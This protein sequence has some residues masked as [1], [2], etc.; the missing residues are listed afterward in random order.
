M[1]RLLRLAVFT[2]LVT[3]APAAAQTPPPATPVVRTP[4][5][6]AL[7]DLSRA[8]WRWMADQHM[9]SLSALFHDEAVFVH[10]GGTMPR[11]TELEIIRS[12]GIRYTHAEVFEAS[13]RVLG[14][15]AIVL[16]RIRLDAIV[17]G[18]AVTNPFMVTEVYVRQGSGW[19]L[20]ALSFTRLLQ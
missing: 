3:A 17:G 5:E 10:M 15:T 4:T 2:A 18:N 19:Q 11:A 7:L 13:V 12:G 8:K 16:N 1:T 20:A 6:Q 14:S 9:D